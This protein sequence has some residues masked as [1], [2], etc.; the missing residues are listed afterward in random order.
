MFLSSRTS[1]WWEYEKR[2]GARAEGEARS[3][4]NESLAHAEPST[5]RKKVPRVTGRANGRV[6]SGLPGWVGRCQSGLNGS[7]LFFSPLLPLALLAQAD[8]A[9]EFGPVSG[10]SSDGAAFHSA[11][12]R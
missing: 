10:H 7:F 11:N 2:R 1:E 5:G 3:G 8:E 12:A 6:S 4:M 9:R